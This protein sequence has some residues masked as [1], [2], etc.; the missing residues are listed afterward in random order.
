[1]SKK[2]T[3]KQIEAMKLVLDAGPE[4]LDFYWYPARGRK[5]LINGNCE[6]SLSRAGLIKTDWRK[7]PN[8]EKGSDFFG[9]SRKFAVLTETGLQALE[10]LS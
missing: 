9:E 7:G 6:T 3:P 2:L 5:V 4:G 8:G 1:M 10:G